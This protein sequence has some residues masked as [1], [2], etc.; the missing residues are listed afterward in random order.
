MLLV[1]SDNARVGFADGMRILRRGGR[2]L[3]AVEAAIRQVE[4]NPADHSV[5]L[6]GLPNIVGEVEL[7]ASLM[8]GRT[9]EAGSVCAVRG[10]PHVITLARAVMGRLPHVLIAGAGA[11]RLAREVG[12]RRRTLLTAAARATYR[13]KV[14][15]R[16]G[17][18]G[19]LVDRVCEATR[20]PEI[21]AT[22]RD[23]FGTVNVIALDRRGDLASGVSTSGWAWKYPGRVGDSPLI[24]AGNYA[25]N[26]YGACACTGYGEMA[27]RG[28]TAHSVV[29]YMKMGRSLERAGRAAMTDLRRLTVPFAPRMNLVAVSPRGG[30][31]G[32]TSV[33]TGEVRYAYQTDR[34]DAP[35]TRPRLIVP[36][37]RAGRRRST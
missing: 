16:L 34:M 23:Y 12:M 3:D 17:R 18:R 15:G 4:A 22:T 25:D 7:D 37:G 6:G 31:V 20:D 5:G 32:L 24:G 10:Y 1:G 30:H 13:R 19:R 2:A 28:A 9:L 26:R 8:D 21:A 35:A 29:L 33:T 11:E 14:T 27:I 36:L